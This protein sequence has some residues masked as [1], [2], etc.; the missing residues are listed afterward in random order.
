MSAQSEAIPDDS[1]PV[2]QCNRA[3]V[4]RGDVKPACAS[5]PLHLKA[6]AAPA[7]IARGADNRWRDP[8]GRS[9]SEV[10]YLRGSAQHVCN[11]DAP[12][13]QSVRQT[14]IAVAAAGGWMQN[15]GGREKVLIK[16]KQSG[17]S[18]G[19]PGGVMM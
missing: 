1:L 16:G 18:G 6:A 7:L 14:L 15:A 8:S 5:E 10:D 12:S 13:S 11:P 17:A 9:V 2:R 3:G 19:G 4:R